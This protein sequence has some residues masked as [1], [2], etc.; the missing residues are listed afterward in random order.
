MAKKKVEVKSKRG[1]KIEIAPL[2]I[3]TAVFKL[4]GIGSMVMHSWGQK[5]VAQM[6]GKQIGEKKAVGNDNKDPDAIYHSS[7]YSFY[8]EGSKK[9]HYGFPA[10]AFRE[11][12]LRSAK[13]LK[14]TGKLNLDKI[15]LQQSIP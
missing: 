15:Q 11:A 10:V 2:N 13:T 4:E 9:I 6:L 5:A 1:E 8:K 3:K 14:D 12:M 7:Y